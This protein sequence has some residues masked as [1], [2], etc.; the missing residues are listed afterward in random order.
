MG[1]GERTAPWIS[2]TSLKNVGSWN[3]R[4]GGKGFERTEPGMEQNEC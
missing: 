3:K 1:F 4:G 2:Y